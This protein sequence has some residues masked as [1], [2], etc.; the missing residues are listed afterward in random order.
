MQIIAFLT[1]RFAIEQILDHLGLAPTE[2][3]KPPPVRELLRVAEQG[4]GW[5]VP[6]SWAPHFWAASV[7][8]EVQLPK[9][10]TGVQTP[11]RALAPELAARPPIKLP[12]TR[13]D[14]PARCNG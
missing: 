13:R 3:A 5:G 9:R 2:E 6:A 1:D 14:E 8:V 7:G 10:L 4:E 11:P 12:V